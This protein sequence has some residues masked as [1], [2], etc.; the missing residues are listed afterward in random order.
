MR[1]SAQRALRKLGAHGPPAVADPAEKLRATIQAEATAL[2]ADRP[3]Y[4]DFRY[5]EDWR[6]MT[7]PAF[8][9]IRSATWPICRIVARSSAGTA[10]AG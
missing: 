4:Q 8:S 6:A 9:T 7:D 3:T 1:P 2:A 10:D 5:D